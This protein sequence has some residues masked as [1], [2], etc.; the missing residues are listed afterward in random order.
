[1]ND[2]EKEIQSES[3]ISADDSELFW[4]HASGVDLQ[5]SSQDK[6]RKARGRGDFSVCKFKPLH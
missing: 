6:G 4:C 5:R 3:G 1:M 2:P